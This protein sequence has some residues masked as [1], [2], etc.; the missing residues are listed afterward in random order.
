[1]VRNWPWN[2]EF[3]AWQRGAQG[4]PLPNEGQG[5]ALFRAAVSALVKT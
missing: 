5:L 2:P 1:M 3:G 4:L